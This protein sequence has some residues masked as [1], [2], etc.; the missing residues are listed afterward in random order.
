[1]S[2]LKICSGPQ[3]DYDRA[4]KNYLP[5]FIGIVK[6]YGNWN[7]G[8]SVINS[9]SENFDQA[10]QINLPLFER[11]ITRINATLRE[12]NF[13]IFG[14]RAYPINSRID[15]LW[16]SVFTIYIQVLQTFCIYSRN[17]KREAFRTLLNRR[18]KKPMHLLL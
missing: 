3:Q 5:N 9:V 13:E 18:R 16:D 8:F 1:M 6:A 15:F 17:M 4:S 14:G 12:E 2:I 7:F 11:E 10:D